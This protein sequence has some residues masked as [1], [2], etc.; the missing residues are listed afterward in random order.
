MNFNSEQVPIMYRAQIDGRCSLQ[1]PNKK[2]QIN[3]L[4][5][6]LGHKLG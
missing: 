1:Y 4:N 5:N 6:M 2:N 3:Y